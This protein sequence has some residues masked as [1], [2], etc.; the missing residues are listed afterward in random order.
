MRKV[1]QNKKLT[2]EV[3]LEKY[4]IEYDNFDLRN[5]SDILEAT[6]KIRETYEDGIDTY[7]QF[8]ELHQDVFDSLYKYAPE[9]V[10]SNRIKY[11]YLLNSK[12]MDA[13]LNSSK[14][15]EMRLLTRLDIVNSTIG[16]Q[17]I[18]DKV[19]DLVK[20]LQSQFEEILA[21][22]ERA[23]EA[24]NDS[25]EEGDGKSVEGPN[26]ITKDEAK[27]ILEESR[28][29][30]DDLI[31]EKEEYKI[32]GILQEALA[33][34]KETSDIIRH[35][36]LDQD[37]GFRKTGHQE[38]LQILDQIRNSEKLKSLAEMAGRYKQWAI[39]TQKSKTKYGTQ[40]LRGI[41]LGI[42]I[43][44][45]LPSESMKLKHPALKKLFKKNFLEAK[46]DQYE[47]YPMSKESKGP[48]VCCLDSSGSMH[49]SKEIWGKAVA[50]GLLEIA[51]HQK[52]SFYVIHFSSNW[53]DE[54]LHINDFSKHKAYSTVQMIDMAEYFEGGGTDFETPL[55]A[56]Q[57]K[58]RQSPEY[59]KADIV[60][61]TDG[62]SAVRDTWVK[63]FTSWKKSSDVKVYSVLVDLGY[64]FRST[65]DEFS[66]EV[67]KISRL[68]AKALDTTASVLFKAL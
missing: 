10:D 62:E 47:Y 38:K 29:K 12:V 6:P 58:I 13:V 45:L 37:P 56:A 59:T 42:D 15:K 34:A 25:D 28:E 57:N 64:N 50:L 51:R 61:I 27:K 36:G 63:Q 4:S 43:G 46:L 41:T 54:V 26:A 23:Q 44:K 55:N 22:M 17:V 16:T 11:D 2:D 18:G 30:L 48:I 20:D 3:K 8:K 52:R 31:T 33:E 21:N 49:G 7:P 39:S 65:L 9:K 40:S 19:K 66:D 5:F 67:H 68:T 14:Y 53:S 1:D 32:Q 35:W 24:L 60:F